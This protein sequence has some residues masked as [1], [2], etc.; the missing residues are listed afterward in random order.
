MSIIQAFREREGY[1]CLGV[2]D[3]RVLYDQ[4]KQKIS[5][6]YPRQVREIA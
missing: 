5:K 2:L 3:G 1:K 6:E 4:I